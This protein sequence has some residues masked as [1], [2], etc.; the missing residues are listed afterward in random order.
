M[1]F[2]FGDKN[3]LR[4]LDE[5]EFWK[6]QEQ[7]HTVVIRKI[8]NNLEEKYVKQL[9][10]FQEAFNQAE[11]VAIRYIETVIRSGG[12]ISSELYKEIMEFINYLS[13][14][15]KQFISLLDDM[16]K[17]SVSVKSNPVSSVVINHIRRE[18]EYF[19]GITQ[20]ILSN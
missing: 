19:V 3:I 14:Q 6:K 7:E 20:A 16:L 18:S 8:V 1:R 2:Y 17:N 10:E 11:G 9:E 4:A 12:K 15:S 13:L 5:A